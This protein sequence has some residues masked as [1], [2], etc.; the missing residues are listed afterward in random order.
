MANSLWRDGTMRAAIVAAAQEV[1]Q[2]PTDAEKGK[3]PREAT[4]NL[5]G[6]STPEA[7]SVSE[8]E[9]IDRLQREVQKLPLPLG[10]SRAP[11]DLRRVPQGFRGWLAKIVGLLLTAIAVSLG[12]PF[13]FDLLNKLVS[14][15]AAGKPPGKT[16]EGKSEKK[17]E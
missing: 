14:L 5:P 13:W 2:H 11:D 6:E 8:E 1:A 7:T 3:R 17:A 16:S 4:G 12:A 15:R 10:W 9:I